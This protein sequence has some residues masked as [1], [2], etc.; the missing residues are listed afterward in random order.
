M[1]FSYFPHETWVNQGSETKEGQKSQALLPNSLAHYGCDFIVHI[2]LHN[3][4]IKAIVNFSESLASG[5]LSG[6]Y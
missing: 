6:S 1:L 4:W 3:N 2:Y 5:L